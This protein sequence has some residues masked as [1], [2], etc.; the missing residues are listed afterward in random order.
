[1]KKET[2]ERTAAII[3]G[4]IMIFSMVGFAGMSIITTERGGGQVISNV[5]ERELSAEEKIFVLRTG[6]VLLESYYAEN[7]T[8]CKEFNI[9]GDT[10]ANRFSEYVVFEKVKGNMTKLQMIGQGGEIK[11][12]ETD[13]SEEGLFDAFCNLAILQPKECLL[14]DI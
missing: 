2:R 1:M 9:L 7:C 4:L 12:L 13:I 14:K 10:F 8:G 3:L 11:D 5:I 6:R